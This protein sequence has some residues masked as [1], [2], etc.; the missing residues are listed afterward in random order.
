MKNNH[1]QKKIY[2]KNLQINQYPF[3]DVVSY[4]KRLNLSKKKKQIKIL[5]IGCGC[6]NN[7]S[8]LAQDGF[9][10]SGIDFSHKAV[11]IAKNVFRKKKLSA[12]LVVGNIKKL[13]W[14]NEEFDYVFDR[15]VLTHNSY[16]DIPI[17]LDEVR[18]VLKKKGTFVSFDLFSINIPN[19]K[20]FVVLG[21]TSFFNLRG[22][23]KM[24]NKFNL[25]KIEKKKIYNQKNKLIDETFFVEGI[26]K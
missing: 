10:V 20:N 5:E 2:E 18:R 16:T 19:K 17:I 12:D 11:K 26:K 3:S 21:L 25:K 9:K 7:L 14:P 8:F 22:I 6:G 24:F 23:K 13:N 15:A 4:F 1:W